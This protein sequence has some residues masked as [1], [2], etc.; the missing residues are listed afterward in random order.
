[1][2]EISK[3][4]LE[5]LKNKLLDEKK[6]LTKELSDIGRIN[7]DNPLDWE[8]VPEKENPEDHADENIVADHKESFEERSALLKELEIRYNN[9]FLALEKIEKDEYGVCEVGGTPIELARLEANPAARTC[10]EH[11]NEG[12]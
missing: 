11:M 1:M 7:P 4:K 12:S 5:E 10:K 8:P 6:V 3:E 2:S 9:V